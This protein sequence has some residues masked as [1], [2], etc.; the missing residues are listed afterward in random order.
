M[1]ASAA[2]P[3]PRVLGFA[4]GRLPPA[5]PVAAGPAMSRGGRRARA[6]TRPRTRPPAGSWAALRD[7]VWQRD[8][9][10]RRKAAGDGGVVEAKHEGH[11][12][13]RAWQP[14]ARADLRPQRHGDA[15]LDVADD[16][17][18]DEAE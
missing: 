16:L 10:R 18:A 3:G 6:A 17:R 13:I 1:A 14:V 2:Q 7:D 9:V 12:P 4:A 8:R 5:S 15:A 11:R